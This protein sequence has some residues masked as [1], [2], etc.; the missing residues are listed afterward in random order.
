MGCVSD[1]EG[2]AEGSDD[3]IYGDE[4][5]AGRMKNLRPYPKKFRDDV[6]AIARCRD[7][8]VS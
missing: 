4:V 2:T 7:A 8:P 3:L 5:T 1:D 6:L